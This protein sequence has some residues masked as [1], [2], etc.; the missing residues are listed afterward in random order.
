MLLNQFSNLMTLQAFDLI[1]ALALA[2]CWFALYT[3]LVYL[4]N[5]GTLMNG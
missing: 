5:L 1:I 4:Q 3:S 2:V